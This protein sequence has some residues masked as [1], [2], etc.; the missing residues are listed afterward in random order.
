MD[1]WYYS[2]YIERDQNSDFETPKKKSNWTSTT[3]FGNNTL[4]ITKYFENG[5]G[6]WSAIL[7][8]RLPTY[9]TTVLHPSEMAL[10]SRPGVQIDV[11]GK[12]I[13][14]HNFF[15]TTCMI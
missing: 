4:C 9:N 14:M 6:N 2:I 13:A 15:E 5:V 8:Y 7:F 10:S 11:Q 12:E 1:E 3:E